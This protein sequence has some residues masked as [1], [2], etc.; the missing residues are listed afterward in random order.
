MKSGVPQGTV[1]GPVL[2]LLYINDITENLQSEIRLFADGCI[3]YKVVKNLSDSENL[4][5]GI[6][7]LE[8]GGTSDR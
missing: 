1:L 3:L 2:F 7:Q 4:Q 8:N 5:R 6:H